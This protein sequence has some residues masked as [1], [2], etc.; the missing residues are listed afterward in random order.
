M[1]NLKKLSALILALVM[2][3]SLCVNVVALDGNEVYLSP[4]TGT[5]YT[6]IT[7]G[8]SVVLEVL[9]SAQDDEYN[10]YKTGFNT[11]TEAENIS[12]RAKSDPS[13]L[14]VSIVRGSGTDNGLITATGTISLM[15][16]RYGTAII[17]AKYGEFTLDLVICVESSTTVSAVTG[18]SVEVLDV[19][20]DNT[21]YTNI[22]S[23]GENMTVSSINATSNHPL[24]NQTSTAKT[25]PTALNALCQQVGSSNMVVYGGY[26]SEITAP[27]MFTG[28][29]ITLAAYS[30]E[31]WVNSYGW[32]YCVIRT[33][34]GEKSIVEDSINLSSA[35]L[36][37]QN[38]D[39]VYWAFGT[40]DEA[41]EYFAELA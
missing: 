7:N 13:G 32:N 16:N 19:R 28:E 38:G 25:F 35:V 5:E 29:N 22:Y 20:F 6:T 3:L 40:A 41:A 12:W 15:P 31:G 27:D 18:I 14:V 24:S 33:V 4:A 17:E 37:L 10:W 9:F 1:K 21:Y 39:A 34:N 36:P 11:T 2:A 23:Q 8:S 26:V 30:D